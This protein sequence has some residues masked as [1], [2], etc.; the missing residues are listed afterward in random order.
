MG[1]GLFWVIQRVCKG[2]LLNGPCCGTIV[3]VSQI[4]GYPYWGPSKKGSY[5]LGGLP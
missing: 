3:E 1:P 4:S 5:S 2:S